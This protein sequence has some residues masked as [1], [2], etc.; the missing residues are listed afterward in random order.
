MADR[1][2]SHS[3]IALASKKTVSPGRSRRFITHSTADSVSSL[4]ASGPYSPIH[5]NTMQGAGVWSL[6]SPELPYPPLTS[7]PQERIFITLQYKQ[8]FP[9]KGRERSLSLLSWTLSMKGNILFTLRECK[10]IWVNWLLK[11]SWE[12]CERFIKN[13]LPY[14]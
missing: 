8:I 2:S 9:E 12:E 5:L 7:H 14:P 1:L 11:P 6:R 3:P 10:Q 13:C 4:F